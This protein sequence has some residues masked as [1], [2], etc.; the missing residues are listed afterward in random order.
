MSLNKI[1]NNVMDRYNK[2][3]IILHVAC[4]NFS[5]VKIIHLP[6]NKVHF[7]QLTVTP[8]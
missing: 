2:R 6:Y 8:I 3:Y 1:G 4:H 5:M 7:E